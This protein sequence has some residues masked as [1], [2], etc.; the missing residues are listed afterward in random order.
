M[1]IDCSPSVRLTTAPPQKK[2]VRYRKL[3]CMEFVKEP[4]PILPILDPNS[5]Y[6]LYKPKQM[7]H[8]MFCQTTK[9][10]NKHYQGFEIN[11]K[12]AKINT[13]IT[14]GVIQ[15]PGQSTREKG[16]VGRN[17]GVDVGDDDPFRLELRPQHC[18]PEPVVVGRLTCR[19]PGSK[20]CGN[21]STSLSFGVYI[22]KG[23]KWATK[24]IVTKHIAVAVSVCTVPVHIHGFC[25]ISILDYR[26]TGTYTEYSRLATLPHTAR[27]TRPYLRYLQYPIFIDI[28]CRSSN[29]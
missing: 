1:V 17:G 29:S 4:Q 9:L 11:E 6:P 20:G 27:N 26:K 19:I 5:E 18:A 10:C 15:E 24:K 25:I 23:N 22:G 28:Q 21:G 16:I 2:Y 8:Y 12:C 7:P 14:V 13:P 3:H